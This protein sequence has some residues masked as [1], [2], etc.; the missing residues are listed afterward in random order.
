[1]P[2]TKIITKHDIFIR[3]D[4]E[5]MH[6]ESSI[7]IGKDKTYT[8]THE[9]LLQLA[10]TIKKGVAKAKRDTKK[11]LAL[12]DRHRSGVCTGCRNNYYNWEK[13]ESDTIGVNV[14]TGYSCW[15]LSEVKRDR[16]RMYR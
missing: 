16:C 13:E 12:R 8:L 15:W 4:E 6:R 11:R 14:P 9:E 5:L 1:M 7:K 2:E 3:V 10:D